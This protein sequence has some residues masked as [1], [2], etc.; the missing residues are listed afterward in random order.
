MQCKQGSF[1]GCTTSLAQLSRGNI[2]RVSVKPTA[3]TDRN[4]TTVQASGPS[5]STAVHQSKACPSLTLGR[6]YAGRHGGCEGMCD[7]WVLLHQADSFKRS[8]CN[9]QPR[10]ALRNAGAAW[11][12]IDTVVNSQRTS[13]STPTAAPATRFLSCA[14][15]LVLTSLNLSNVCLT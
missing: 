12:K 5:T 6:I 7:M 3:C 11:P 4:L 8:R 14:M 2:W 15:L 1:S 10:A 13:K 9:S